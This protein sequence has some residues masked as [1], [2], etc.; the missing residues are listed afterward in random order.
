M[1]DVDNVVSFLLEHG[2][3]QT[4]WIISGELAIRG[5]A[6]TAIAASGS[7]DPVARDT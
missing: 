5:A 1:L 4:D 7:R 2:L 3:V 6:R